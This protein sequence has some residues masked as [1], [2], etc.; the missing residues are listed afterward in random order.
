MKLHG[1]IAAL[2]S[3]LL[4]SGSL[5]AAPHCFVV[6]GHPGDSSFGASIEA[7]SMLWTE[8][9][10]KAGFETKYI[11]ARSGEGE[12]TPLEKIRSELGALE[13]PSLD[14]LWL[15]LTGHG[16]A[17]GTVPRFALTGADL[18]A[19]ELAALLVKI[20]RPTIV[21]LGFSCSGAFVKALAA[22]NRQIIAATR[23]AEEENW[24]RF[25]K[26]FAEAITSLVADADSDG[27]VSVFEAWLAAVGS[28]EGF[29]KDTGR[30]VT[31][32]AV[33][34]DLGI[35]KPQGR[36]AF[37]RF[38]EYSGKKLEDSGTPGLRA[39]DSFLLSSPLESVLSAEEHLKRAELE[40]K[41]ARLR[42]EKDGMASEDYRKVVEAVFLELAAI[43]EGA[44][45]RLPSR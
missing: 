40:R 20:K 8:A 23:S 35:G 24:T 36:E 32:H 17:Q 12:R 7:T 44:Q 26:F 45:K 41:L 4:V 27:Q 14:P 28:V 16:N 39:C 38:G 30:L 29:Y 33:F 15:V 43:Y 21:V 5:K 34:E 10:K 25:P 31:E 9:A 19:D 37:D 1:F 6:S 11:P 42:G 13:G 2:L 3:A 18:G 22:P